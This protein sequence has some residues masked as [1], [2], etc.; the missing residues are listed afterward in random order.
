MS[1]VAEVIN[2]LEQ[3]GW[4]VEFQ[5]GNSPTSHPCHVSITKEGHTRNVRL[6]SWEIT[7]NGAATGTDRP[8]DERRIQVTRTL[9]NEGIIMGAGFDTY[10]L[11]FS[12]QFS[13]VPVIASFN[14]DGVASRINTK[15]TNKADL[16]EPNPRVSDSQQIKQAHINAA[17]AQGVTTGVNQKGDEFIVVRANQISRLFENGAEAVI[18]Q[19]EA[20]VLEPEAAAVQ[21]IA[22][23]QLQEVD[24]GEAVSLIESLAENVNVTADNE[25]QVTINLQQRREAQRRHNEVVRKFNN[26]IATKVSSAVVLDRDLPGQSASSL[27]SCRPDLGVRMNPGANPAEM[28][29]LESKSLPNDLGGQWTQVLIGIGEL[30]RYSHEYRQTH[31]GQPLQILALEREP[32][33]QALSSFLEALRENNEVVVVW[34]SDEGFESFESHKSALEWLFDD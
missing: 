26:E 32:E 25:M 17:V 11:G 34:D 31:G 3:D 33:D 24:A 4:V 12:D 18:V 6:Y 2:A 28:I 5:Q 20:P 15:L 19:P 13:D 14:P 8:E 23:N 30:A 1:T 21:T 7:D 16:G 29:I 27:Q 22:E 10:V 9:A